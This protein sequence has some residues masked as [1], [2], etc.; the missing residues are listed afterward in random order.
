[1]GNAASPQHS[2]LLAPHLG[3]AHLPCAAPRATGA[4]CFHHILP[5]R[6]DEEI[7]RTI[8]VLCR[9]TKNNPVLIGAFTW[10]FVFPGPVSVA[11][12]C[13]CPPSEPPACTAAARLS[14]PPFS[15]FS[16]HRIRPR[17]R[18]RGTPTPPV[19]PKHGPALRC[20]RARAAAQT[21]HGTD[22]KGVVRAP[23]LADAGESLARS[24]SRLWT[25]ETR[26]PTLV[27]G[28]EVPKEVLAA[29][30]EARVRA[31]FEHGV[32]EEVAHASAG[33]LS[34]TAAQVIGLREVRELPRE[35]AGA[36]IVRRTLQYAAYQR[37]WMRRVPG[38]IT[39]AADH[40]PASVAEALLA[41]VRERF[42]LLGQ[43]EEGACGIRKGEA[44]HTGHAV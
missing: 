39:L 4:S 27:F 7:R 2:D 17:A 8:R 32:E 20:G 29:R 18:P 44:D 5:C 1:L 23:G 41:A 25:R 11:I 40:A 30:I 35:E 26:H 42:T 10:R 34:N 37:K 31:M 19:G 9:R 15:L 38:L 24:P 28:L 36:A 3:V 22:R 16:L 33:S 12:C 13:S 21:A 43:Q 6:R 14:P